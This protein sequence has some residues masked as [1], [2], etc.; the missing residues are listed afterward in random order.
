MIDL[1]D[2]LGETAP[3]NVLDET[4]QNLEATETEKRKQRLSN[5]VNLGLGGVAR[6]ADTGSGITTA[7]TRGVIGEAGTQGKS[8]MNQAI[9][10]QNQQQQLL[11]GLSGLPALYLATRGGT[12]G[13]PIQ[14]Q[15]MLTGVPLDTAQGYGGYA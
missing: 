8:L 9:L 4:M 2:F 12:T 3:Q 13:A 5:L 1:T 15:P 7:G 10:R 6:T 11:G 14:Q